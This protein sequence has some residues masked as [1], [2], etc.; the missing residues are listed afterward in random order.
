MPIK[1]NSAGGGSVTINAA[2]TAAATV[3]TVPATNA[4]IITDSS[5]VLNIGSGQLYKDASGNIG[6]GTSSPA[7]KADIQS[8]TQRTT[9]TGTDFGVLN[10]KSTTAT[11]D[12]TGLTFQSSAGYPGSKIAYQ[13]TASGGQ[14]AFGVTNNYGSGITAESM[15]IDS[16]GRVMIPY[17]PA[18]YAYR[19]GATFNTSSTEFIFDAT[20]LNRGSYYSTTTGRFT[21]PV[22]GAYFFSA[23]GLPNSA[24]SASFL[25]IFKNNG[26]WSC[27]TY[28]IN[29]DESVSLSIVMDMAAGDFAS[30]YV[31][32]DGFES[33]YC[34]FSG[35]LIG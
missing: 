17:Q 2:S 35:F 27:S 9:F 18:F 15:R 32:S 26:T 12:Y 24:S 19:A 7:A 34:C 5:D 16:S 21:A 1:L 6:I 20:R 8:T 13:Q 33:S 11:G 23:T 10:L 28:V 14:L 4:N 22:A 25:R 3:L 31:A 30:V 29:A